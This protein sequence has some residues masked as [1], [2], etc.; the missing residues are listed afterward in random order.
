MYF[1]VLWCTLVEI[2]DG[3][4]V[5]VVGSVLLGFMAEQPVGPTPFAL[6]R[7]LFMPELKRDIISDQTVALITG[8]M[9]T[10]ITLVAHLRIG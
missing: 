10:R 6:G 2:T 1:G 9:F 4:S 3:E 8:R 7:I 5:P